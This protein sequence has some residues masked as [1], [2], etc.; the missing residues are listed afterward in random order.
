MR[1]WPGLLLMTTSE[2]LAHAEGVPV[3]VYEF[4]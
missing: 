1:L 4:C 3:Q 2:E